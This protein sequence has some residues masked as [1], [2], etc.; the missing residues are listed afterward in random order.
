VTNSYGSATSNEAALTLISVDF[1]EDGDVDLDDFASLQL[2]L[3][4]EHVSQNN[5]GCVEADLNDDN[6][7]D[8]TDL[9]EFMGCMNGSGIPPAQGCLD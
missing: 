7:V 8:Q 6:N 3:G 1:D 2:C 4:A 9:Q 5:P